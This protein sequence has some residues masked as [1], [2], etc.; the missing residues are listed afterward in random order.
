MSIASLCT[1][2][3]V[4]HWVALIS[5]FS[6]DAGFDAQARTIREHGK[7]GDLVS[8]KIIANSES[9]LAEHAVIAAFQ[10]LATDEA[11]TFSECIRTGSPGWVE[12]CALLSKRDRDR[13]SPFFVKSIRRACSSDRARL[14][15]L[16]IFSDWPDLLEFAV[17][18][19]YCSSPVAWRNLPIGPPT[20]TVGEIARVC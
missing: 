17:A 5:L 7:T 13:V 14:Y 19:I 18:D 1:L 4:G 3:K 9:I 10:R 8:L 16:C 2:F 12:A 11:I 15:S 6:S 20:P